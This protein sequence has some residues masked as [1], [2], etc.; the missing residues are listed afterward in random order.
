MILYTDG[1][2]NQEDGAYGSW[3]LF[4][5]DTPNSCIDFVTKEKYP[6]IDTNNGA[7][8]TAVLK[9]LT[10]CVDQSVTEV[11]V[12]SDSKLIINQLL[13]KWRINYPHLQALAEK[14]W[15]VMEDFDIIQLSHV[16]RDVI[17]SKLGH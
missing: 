12:R 8:Y 6:K 10:Y 11:E 3:A 4:E 9:G 13:G 15:K 17:V 5:Y 16:S 7:E 2:L 1:G 14:V